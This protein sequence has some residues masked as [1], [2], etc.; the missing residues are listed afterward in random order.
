MSLGGRQDQFMPDPF[1]LVHAQIPQQP[2][3]SDQY[4]GKI[5]SSAYI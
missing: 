4:V 3:K 1:E 2:A 5:R